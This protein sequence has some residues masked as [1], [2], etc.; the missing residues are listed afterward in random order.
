MEAFLSFFETM[1][2]WMKAAWI[3]GCLSFFWI[4]EGNYS[5]F[6]FDYKRWKHAGTNM[7]LLAMVMIINVA[8][9]L[10]LAVIFVWLESSNF[11]LLHVLDSPIW[12]ELLLSIFVLDFLAQYFVHYL[13]HKVP[14]MWRLHLVH[15]TDKTVD[16]TT[17]TRHHPIDFIIREAMAIVAVVIMGMPISFYLFY[18]IITI[19][20]TYFNHANLSLPRG[21]DKFL[22]YLIVSPNMHKFHHHHKM[23]WT[24]SNFGNMFSIWDRMFGTFVYEDT[25]DI[26]Y[27]VDIADHLDD[28]NIRVQLGIPFN[29]SVQSKTK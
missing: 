6:S 29:K 24:D 22:S 15:H 10:I 13:L 26:I 3:F 4:F 14:W 7:M 19:L 28:Q 12:I 23:P 27:G 21:L 16:V 2:I 9:S 8:V 18:R 11:G 5:L 1:P 25:K 17:G 20:F